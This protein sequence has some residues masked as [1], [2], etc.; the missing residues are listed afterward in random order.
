MSTATYQYPLPPYDQEQPYK[1]L[2]Y[3]SP[4]SLMKGYRTRPGV[5]ARA[6]SI[7]SLPLPQEPGYD[8]MHEYNISNDNPVSPV[9]TR[10][11][12]MNS[13]GP[14]SLFNRLIQPAFSFFEKTFATST[15]R[16]FSNIGEMSMVAEG[17]K[18]YK[19]SYIF[20]PK[21]AA[22]AF[23]VDS[24]CGTFRKFS[25][26][27]AA[28][29]YP[30]RSFPQNLWVIQAVSGNQPGWGG[31]TDNIG[32][33]IF[34]DPLVCV[35][36]SMEVKRADR[37]DPI[38][39]YLPNGSSNVTLLGLLFQEFETGSYDFFSNSVISKSEIANRYLR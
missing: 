11:G 22:E 6:R 7:I 12:V 10:A 34:G 21:S 17:R 24:I 3:T 18:I 28:L 14:L 38:I 39:R 27:E 35:L 9:L 5:K 30:E 32:A 31:Y 15:Y 25:Y 1:L 19:F 36:K 20:T 23:Q 4:Y 8:I 33:E 29:P 16:R 2:F 26:P 37:D 13:G